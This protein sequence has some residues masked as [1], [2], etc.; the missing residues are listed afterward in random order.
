[1]H[2]LIGV[3]PEGK[4]FIAKWP[5]SL[6]TMV[7]T[8]QSV[9]NCYTEDYVADVCSLPSIPCSYQLMQAL[10]LNFLSEAQI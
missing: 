6:A 4:A 7:V 9:A 3:N 5:V 8:A 10:K 2:T 1:M